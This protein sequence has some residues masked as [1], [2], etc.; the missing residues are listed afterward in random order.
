MEKT[1]TPA[2]GGTTPEASA[3]G[4]AGTVA[5]GHDS[6]WQGF[7][8]S[9]LQRG[10]ENAIPATR[11]TAL[12]G[13]SESRTLRKFVDAER[14]HGVPIL[15]CTEGYFLPSADED[16]AQRELKI[17]LRMLARRLASN[18]AC[19]DA[20]RTELQRITHKDQIMLEAVIEDG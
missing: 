17:Y 3:S 12:L 5:Q 7:V 16:T 8:A 18:R 20:A 4:L 14:S 11:L 2:V 10:R 15:A 13:L 6:T 19:A 9:V 1:K